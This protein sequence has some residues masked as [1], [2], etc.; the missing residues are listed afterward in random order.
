MLITEFIA[1]R[2]EGVVPALVPRHAHDLNDF[3]VGE[4]GRPIFAET[5]ANLTIGRPQWLRR[6]KLMPHC[7]RPTKRLNYL[8]KRV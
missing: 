1:E 4:F 8:G 5:V 7:L 6:P 2:I 3:I